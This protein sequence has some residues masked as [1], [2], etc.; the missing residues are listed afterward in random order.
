M[1]LLGT[2]THGRVILFDKVPTDLILGDLILLVLL[3][4]GGIGRCGLSDMIIIRGIIHVG[5]VGVVRV[6]RVGMRGGIGTVDRGGGVGGHDGGLEN[7]KSLEEFRSIVC[8]IQLIRDACSVEKNLNSCGQRTVTRLKSD[9]IR[10]PTESEKT[11]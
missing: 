8:L 1:K 6:G 11:S 5:V 10:L 9:E 4:G 3:G 7:K 2:T